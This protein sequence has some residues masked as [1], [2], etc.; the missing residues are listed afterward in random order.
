MWWYL[1][2]TDYRRLVHQKD[3]HQNSTLF[4]VL[5]CRT[6]FSYF[7]FSPFSFCCI[8]FFNTTP[9]SNTITKFTLFFGFVSLLQ[10]L[11][12]QMSWLAF[13]FALFLSL[14]LNYYVDRKKICVQH[15]RTNTQLISLTLRTSNW[16]QLIFMTTYTSRNKMHKQWNSV[17]FNFVTEMKIWDGTVSLC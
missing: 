11:P 12:L 3:C 14:K 6:F 10:W 1:R 9:I 5:L 4:F 15:T 2:Q 8:F 13:D 17:E 7:L 16:W